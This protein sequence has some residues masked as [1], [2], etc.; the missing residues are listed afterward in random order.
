MK[1]SVYIERI[2][3]D[4]NY[5]FGLKKPIETSNQWQ[6]TCSEA[7]KE[8][9]N[10]TAD[11]FLYYRCSDGAICADEVE[12]QVVE[13]TGDE[14]GFKEL[15]EY[16]KALAD[17]PSLVLQECEQE[18]GVVCTKVVGKKLKE[19][20]LYLSQWMKYY[21]LHNNDVLLEMNPVCRKQYKHRA[22]AYKS[23]YHFIQEVY[24]SDDE[25][26][27]WTKSFS[28]G[29]I[30]FC[31]LIEWCFEDLQDK[32]IIPGG[33]LTG[34]IES[35]G[36]TTAFV[37]LARKP[38]KLKMIF[39]EDRRRS[40]KRGENNAST[41]TLARDNPIELISPY[42]ALIGTALKLSKQ[43]GYYVKKPR[44]RSAYAKYLSALSGDANHSKNN[45]G[46]KR[47]F[48]SAD[49]ETLDSIEQGHQLKTTRSRKNK[50]K[51][52]C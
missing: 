7:S 31:C 4:P 17:L 26:C 37:Q 16:V 13:K 5:V 40:S 6:T 23:L 24:A 11:K 1:K 33:K 19:Y 36:N 43:Y 20:Y 10:K 9:W 52:F 21:L 18:N 3:E 47:E 12:G 8:V 32:G 27:R 46:M 34:K 39:H 22:I 25:I 2:K 30:W 14:A 51:G 35:A 41:E 15:I 50:G 45:S 48:L 42:A 44:N 28:P 29:Q 38:G 49:G